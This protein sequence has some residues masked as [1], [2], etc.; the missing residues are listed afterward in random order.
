M[1][2]SIFYKDTPHLENIIDEIPMDKIKIIIDKT[3][4]IIENTK[5]HK[6][7]I[8]NIKNIEKFIETS[9]EL[10]LAQLKELNII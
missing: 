5:E 10:I 9:V 7:F 1:D 8:F 6:D 4:L 3:S 2:L